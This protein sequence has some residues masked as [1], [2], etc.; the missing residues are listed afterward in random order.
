[1]PVFIPY[2]LLQALLFLLTVF[3]S[4]SAQAQTVHETAR[5]YVSDYQNPFKDRSKFAQLPKEVTD[6]YKSQRVTAET[7][8]RLELNYWDCCD[9]GDVFRTRFRMIEDGSEVRRR[10]V[11]I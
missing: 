8:W 2:S 1:M 7:Y 5:S 10:N 3:T 4:H 6:W 11:R 9:N